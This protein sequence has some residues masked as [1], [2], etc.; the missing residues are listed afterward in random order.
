MKFQIQESIKAR[1]G[2]V[3]DQLLNINERHTWLPA[4]KR[5]DQGD[6]KVVQGAQVTSSYAHLTAYPCIEQ[7]VRVVNNKEIAAHIESPKGKWIIYIILVETSPNTTSMTL[8]AEL[9]PSAWLSSLLLWFE[10]GK[11]ELYAT[12]LMQ[13]FKNHMETQA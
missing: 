12:E 5:E 2:D 10:S 3:F 4:F 6:P 7:Y 1:I 9:Q 8:M 13:R 11:L